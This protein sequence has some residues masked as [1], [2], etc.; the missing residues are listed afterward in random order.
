M[1]SDA[2]G[3][4]QPSAILTDHLV[5]A[6]LLAARVLRSM[7][8][9]S[10][11]TAREAYGRTASNAIYSFRDLLIGQEILEQAG[12]LNEAG[13]LFL[14]DDADLWMALPQEEARETLAGRY[15][16]ALAPL[17]L[18]AATGEDAVAWDLVPDGERQALA[19][20]IPACEEREAFLLG[21][22]RRVDPE[23]DAQ[24][25]A[26]AEEHVV[27][28]C[29]RQLEDAGYSELAARVRRV[30]LV[31]DDLGYDVT[32]PYAGAGSRRL[33]VKGTRTQGPACR[34]TVSRNEA[35]QSLRDPD[36]YLVVCRVDANDSVAVVGW[37]TGPQIEPYL[38]T[39][40]PERGRWRS[41]DITLDADGLSLGLPPC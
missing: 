15:L 40:P 30:S 25:G 9:C 16:A 41:V 7:N 12:L 29:R 5:G 1:S 23:R 27:A 38:P 37:C 8:G 31:S 35:R 14:S 20:L 18:T 33:E 34:I 3:S 32:A 13:G 10:R 4:T 6:A 22:G 17:W 2:A 39:D 24:T 19:A 26:L 11:Q 36:W 21:L 28:A